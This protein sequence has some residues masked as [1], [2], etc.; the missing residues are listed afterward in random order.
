VE[1]AGRR[2]RGDRPLGAVEPERG[3]ARLGVGGATGAGVRV[4][5]VDSGVEVG[6]RLVG[7]VDEAVVVSRTEDGEIDIAPDEEGDLCGHGTAVAGIIRSI[8]PECSLSSARVLGA[9]FRGSSAV[10]L[11]GLR[12]AIEQ[13]YHVVNLSLSTTKSETAP[14][15]RE[16]ADLAYFRRCLVV[17]SAHNMPIESF[18]WRF[19]SVLSVGSHEGDDPLELVYNPRPPVEFFARGLDIE[20]AWP[21]G[22]TIRSTG[23][24]FA[25]PH[26]SAIAALVLS[27]YPGL[28]PFQ[29]K[30]VLSLVADTRPPEPRRRSTGTA[31]R[32]KAVRVRAGTRP[33]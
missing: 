17:A 3:D 22:Q 33:T 16:L 23:N 25:T 30:T 24:S 27:K 11:A 2:A 12:W 21:G 8:A 20:V 28:A 18:P 19:S 5:V 6:H 13:G 14:A 26:V 29:L 7:E 32:A 4:C 1:P 15:L 31:S 10:L 9:G